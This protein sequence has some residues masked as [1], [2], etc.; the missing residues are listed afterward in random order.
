M[1]GR[2]PVELPNPKAVPEFVDPA[3]WRKYC[4]ETREYYANH[5]HHGEGEDEGHTQEDHGTRD[6]SHTLTFSV[7]DR[8]DEDICVSCVTYCY[9]GLLAC[10]CLVVPGLMIYVGIRY[11]WCQDIFSPWVI[12]G[13]ILCYINLFI[14]ILH[15]RENKTISLKKILSRD[16]R[17]KYY[18]FLG[19]SLIIIIG[20]VGAFARIMNTF[21]GEG[22][23]G[24]PMM[25][26]PVC[27]FYMHDVI[28]GITTLPF[29]FIF[30]FIFLFCCWAGYAGCCDNDDD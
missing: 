13:G 16:K 17:T 24:A 3:E 14:F 4:Q 30:L 23:L 6:E 21:D 8:C 20:W 15:W 7:P 12:V 18:L 25:S 1:S 19:L 10:C 11:H 26:D 22:W 27:M 2:A 28:W 29:F 5:G 9:L